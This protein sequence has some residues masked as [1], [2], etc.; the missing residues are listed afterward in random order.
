MTGTVLT[1]QSSRRPSSRQMPK[2]KS[3]VNIIPFA[4]KPF[5]ALME[6]TWGGLIWSFAKAQSK[7]E[8]TSC[9]PYL[10]LKSI[11]E[12]VLYMKHRAIDFLS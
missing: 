2:G 12:T 9:A 10:V 4:V 3:S 6:I 1:R 7:K 5:K 8:K 11:N